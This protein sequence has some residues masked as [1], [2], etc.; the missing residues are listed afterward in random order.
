M[1][2]A[3]LERELDEDLVIYADGI[4]DFGTE[5][6]HTP[7]SAIAEFGAI[8]DAGDI[9]FGG[10]PDYGAADGKPYAVIGNPDP[11]VR[12]PTEAQALTW[13]CRTLSGRD[14]S[15]EF[16]V[17]ATWRTHWQAVSDAIGLNRDALANKYLE[18]SR[19]YVDQEEPD[20]S[21]EPVAKEAADVFRTLTLHDL[22]SMPDPVFVIDRHI[23]EQSLGFLYGA[24]G[25]KKSFIALDWALHLAYGRDDWHGDAI[26]TKVDGVVLYL[27]GEGAA[28]MKNRVRAWLQQKGIAESDPRFLRFHLLP[29]SVDLM[30]PDNVKKLARTLRHAIAAPVIAIVVDTVSRALPGADENLQ[31]DMTRFVQACDAI[32]Q[33]FEC[34][35]LGVHHASRNGPMRGSTVL[36]GAGDFVFRLDCKKGKLAGHL[37]CEKQ[38]DAPDGWTDHYR[39]DVVHFGDGASSLVP[40]RVVGGSTAKLTPEIQQ[41]VLEAIDAGWHASTPWAKTRQ[42]KE[43]WAANRLQKDFGISLAEGESFIDVLEQSGRIEMAMCNSNKKLKGYRVVD[44]AGT[45]GADGVFA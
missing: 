33:E 31:K 23:P 28:G 4:Q 15:R 24:P 14:G 44:D 25:S 30:R 1:S 11:T 32:K 19:W 5:R 26:K 34:A 16:P 10:C 12:R 13:L 42:S 17:N 29:H 37:H 22:L 18:A 39:F 21:P 8:D 45:E 3:E 27:A 9:L 35:V 6:S 36:Q 40:I 20:A 7:S 41:Q 43:R 2:S 38:K